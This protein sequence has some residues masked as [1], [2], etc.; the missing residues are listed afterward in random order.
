MIADRTMTA[1]S[2]ADRLTFAVVQV[3]AV[4]RHPRISQSF[5]KRRGR[6]PNFA[7]PAEHGELVQ[8]RKVFDHNPQFTVFCDKLACKRWVTENFPDIPLMTPVWVGDRPEDLPDALVSPG[9]IVK[10]SHGCR[11][12]YFPH[13]RP[14][15]RPDINRLLSRWL[16]RSYDRQGQWGYRDVPRRL[17][18]EPQ[19]GGGRPLTEYSIRAHD[20]VI[21]GLWVVM[22]QHQP[23][24]RSANFAGDGTPMPAKTI[25]H[26]E[27]LPEGYTHPATL[28][29]ARDI[30]SRVSRGFDHI[31][32]DFLVDGDALY[33]GEITVYPGSGFGTE[34]QST[35]GQMHELA[36]FRAL[37]LS[38]FYR[39]PQPWPM[40][41]YQGAFRRWVDSHVADL[42]A[43][44]PADEHSYIAPQL[45]AL[46]D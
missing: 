9:H 42:N 20:G 2:L 10:A 6:I 4:L 23:T 21:S 15:P 14:L 24:E 37:H 1:T 7:R 29:R 22:D 11:A 12:N 39:T 35:Q 16:R 3:L 17:F 40:S 25:K 34:W 38:W 43:S 27:P 30:A 8:W 46:A 13:R 18:V 45:R 44:A 33:L 36:W 5:W 19:V 41:I 26:Q 31:R 32:V 28:H